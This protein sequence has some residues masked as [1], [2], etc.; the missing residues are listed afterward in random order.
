MHNVQFAMRTCLVDPS[1]LWRWRTGK[2]TPR[3]QLS[4]RGKR[5]CGRR[6]K[7]EQ[8]QWWPHNLE[9][10]AAL[11]AESRRSQSVDYVAVKQRA[12]ERVSDSETEKMLS[13][14]KSMVADGIATDLIATACCAALRLGPRI[15][16]YRRQSEHNLREASR[17]ENRTRKSPRLADEQF[18]AASRKTPAHRW[19]RGVLARHN[20]RRPSTVCV[21][22]V[23]SNIGRNMASYYRRS[24]PQRFAEVVQR[25]RALARD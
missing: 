4:R 8:E 6:Y 16:R 11:I 23:F 5:R 24:N 9:L 21:S 19:A 7:Y 20:K 1:T 17:T 13:K 10:A 18:R 14:L 2:S 3:T 12:R 25:L 15:R 22:R